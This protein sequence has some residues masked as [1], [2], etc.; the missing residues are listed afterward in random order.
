M[1][2]RYLEASRS[3]PLKR[4]RRSSS[5]ARCIF[6]RG[7][8]GSPLNHRDIEVGGTPSLEYVC[9]SIRALYA[10]PLKGKQ[11]KH[12]SS[13]YR[14]ATRI[15]EICDSPLPLSPNPPVVSLT[16]VMIAL[17]VQCPEKSSLVQLFLLP[18]IRAWRNLSLHLIF[19]P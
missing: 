5:L 9:S 6:E 12:P 2:L 11:K 19:N 10:R 13:R 8:P 1:P 16:G 15:P 18:T 3:K 17:K 7:M 14:N 4:K